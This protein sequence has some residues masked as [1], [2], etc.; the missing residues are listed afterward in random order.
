MAN[1]RN[2]EALTTALDYIEGNLT[3]PI[4]REEIAAYCF[5][6]LSM[7]EKLFRYALHCSIKDYITKRRI[8]QA[9]GDILKAEQSMTEIAI[10]YQYN[11]PE[12]FCRA[13]FKIWRITPSRFKEKWRFSGIYPKHNFTYTEGDDLEMARKRVDLSDAYDFLKQRRGSYV[14][15]FDIRGMDPINEI[16]RQA[17][18][19]AILEAFSRIDAAATEDMLVMRIG[20]DEF[21]LATGLTDLEAVKHFTEQVISQNGEPF[22]YEEQEIPLTLWSA[23]TTIPEDTLR[24]NELFGKLH[25]VILQGKA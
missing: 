2:F 15:C 20:G 9:A 6:S 21:A 16:S 11:S 19:M 8:T 17:G 13:F 23:V 25:K 3:E 22:R 1:V 18:D 12:V 4:A 10:K 5:V 24:Y 14:I 7:L